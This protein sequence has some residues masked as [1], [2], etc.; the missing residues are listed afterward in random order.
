MASYTSGGEGM[1]GSFEP[2]DFNILH[3]TENAVAD[4]N[5]FGE[6]SR[7][8]EPP[9]AWNQKVYARVPEADSIANADPKK[10]AGTI[11]NLLLDNE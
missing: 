7:S 3:D 2:T 10:L 4:A 8:V 9:F 11:E 5:T 6:M 1:D